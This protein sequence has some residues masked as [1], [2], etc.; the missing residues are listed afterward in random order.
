MGNSA[1]EY[2][3]FEEKVKRTVYIDNLSPLV[4][5]A[6]LKTA[7]GQFGTVESVQFIPNYVEPKNIPQ[8]ALVVTQTE[9]Q[10]KAII[11]EMN[12]F[13]FMMS[14]MPRPV[15]ALPAEVK[16][17][18]D[19]PIKPGRRITCQW[20]DPSDRNFDVA[21]KLKEVTQRHAREASYLLQVNLNAK[22]FD[23]HG[24]RSINL[25]F[26]S[27][28]NCVLIVEI[29]R[30]SLAQLQLEEEEKLA[31][32][33][34]ETLKTNYKKCEMLESLFSDGSHGRLAY[35]FNLKVTDD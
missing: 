27:K 7:L 13:P 17:F 21:Q 25:V 4:T 31:A 6:V 1:E 2:A 29:Q 18:A 16:M 23:C 20:L 30:Y 26:F 32:E 24:F 28:Q 8:C 33:Q 35:R 34:S 22:L 5:D 12:N 9:K 15:R 10:A 11:F 14:G 3:A 19:R